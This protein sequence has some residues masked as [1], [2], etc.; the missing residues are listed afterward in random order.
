[1]L[2]P[3]VLQM[4]RYATTSRFCL[5]EKL[6]RAVMPTAEAIATEMRVGNCI[7]A[8]FGLGGWFVEKASFEVLM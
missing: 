6:G 3:P 8:D 5:V 2:Q 1:M 4:S 7:V